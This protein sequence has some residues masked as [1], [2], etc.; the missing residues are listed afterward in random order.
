MAKYHRPRR[1]S[2]A[3]SPRKRAKK[4]VCRIRRETRVEGKL[5]QGFA[6]YKAGMTHVLVRDSIKG[7]P[8]YG[9]DVFTPVTVIEAPPMRVEGVRIYRVTPYGLKALTEAWKE[10]QLSR[11]E[12]AI[13][14]YDGDELELR[15]IAATQPALI[16]G[17][18]K[19][20][21]DVMELMMSGDVNRD[22]DYVKERLNGEISVKD[23]FEAGDFVDVTAV[24]RGKGFQGPVK[25]WGVKIQ[26]A[27]AQ[28][29]GR[30]RHVG[31]LGPWRPARVRWFVPQAGQTG[32][33]QRT[34]YNKLILKIGEDG[35]E[36]TPEGGFVKYG[37]V[38]NEYLLLKGSVPGPKKRLIRMNLSIRPHPEFRS[39]E[40]T[41]ICTASQQGCR[42]A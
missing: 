38:R 27:K 24:T 17:V 20:K 3:F 8:T 28:R 39:S 4:E 22:Y 19:K 10:Q 31:T 40:I 15:V 34:E 35:S 6:G 26:N 1:G 16:S 42:K 9:Q 7:S 25:R 2:L 12:D 41:F 37:I 30:G 32:Y 29:A 33:H 5:L 14:K 18:P 13:A 11:I 23:V 36:I 21:S